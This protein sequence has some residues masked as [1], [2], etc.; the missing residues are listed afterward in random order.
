MFRP[1][2]PWLRPGQILARWIAPFRS[3]NTYGLFAVMTTSRPE[4]S[5]EGSDDG[6]T[7]R[8]YQFK[9]KPG[10]LERAPRFVA[11]YQP[12]LDWQMW[13]AA[14]GTYRENPWFLSLCGHLLQGSAPVLG[15]LQANP[16]PERPPRYIRALL[17]EYHFTEFEARRRSGDWWQR[18]FRGEYLPAISL[19]NLRS[20]TPPPDSGNR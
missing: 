3:I 4:I 6:Q 14:L 7:W 17:Y 13:F 16:F 20:P 5:I 2:A 9:Y 12:R 8:A 15:L 1:R 10:P 11:P 19:A 18:Q